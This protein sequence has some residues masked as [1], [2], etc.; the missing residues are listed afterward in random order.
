MPVEHG[1]PHRNLVA[2]RDRQRLLQVSPARHRRV[3][4]ALGEAGKDYTQVV[5][6]R[7]DQRERIADLEDDAGVHDVLRGRAPMDVASGFAAHLSELVHERQDR[8]ADDL[9]F[10]PQ[11]IEIEGIHL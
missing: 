4:V 8:I 9:R 1:E 5:Q 6:L 11:E 7:L 3:A 10:V 2:E